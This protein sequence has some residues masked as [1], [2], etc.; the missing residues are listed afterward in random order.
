MSPVGTYAARSQHTPETAEGQPGART[1][2][3]N[4]A[5]RGL[6]APVING[7]GAAN[8]T[9]EVHSDLA[10]AAVEWK[11]FERFADVKPFQ[12][13]GWLDQWQR[14]IGARKGT[15]PVL[16]FGRDEKGAILF[17]LP[18]AIETHH[19]LRRLTFLGAELG[20]YNAPLLSLRFIQHP[21]AESFPA[22]WES[23]VALLRSD[24]RFRFDLVDLPKMPEMVG[25]QKNPLLGLNVMP[26]RSGA[27]VATLGSE[28]ESYYATRRSASTRKTNRRKRKQLEARGHVAFIGE[29]D[30]EAAGQT[31]DTLFAQKSETFARMGVENI[32]SR[33][34]Y[35]EFYRTL[36]TDP[37][38]RDL[39]HVARLNVGTETGATN[40]ALQFR[41]QYYLILSSYH[42]GDLARL[43][44]GREHL[45]EL[46]RHTIERSFRYFDFTI[47]DESYKLDWSDTRL[48]LYDH[49]AACTPRG[50]MVAPYLRFLRRV[51]RFVKQTPLLWRL[52]VKVRAMLGRGIS[53]G[54]ASAEDDE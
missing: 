13:F 2:D 21:A 14:H 19:S 47:G 42:S 4:P 48:T 20:D 43:G 51:T 5:V 24:Q 16:V 33:P 50:M 54:K 11:I 46:L 22:V 10:A 34:G 44:P 53:T 38:L 29:L 25:A 32:L 17:I 7:N 27:Y 12:I 52:A 35:R 49:L 3:T 26:N 45:H 41:G 37:D 30:N 28:W 1:Q 6:G 39:V 23:V 18:L 31:L 9:I 40:M 15:V 8:T 36:A